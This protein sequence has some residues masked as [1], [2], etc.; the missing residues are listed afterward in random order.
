MLPKS[1]EM[2]GGSMKRLLVVGMV[3]SVIY[4]TVGYAQAEDLAKQLAELKAQTTALQKQLKT[5]H[6][7]LK[8]IRNSK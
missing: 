5:L 4:S 7:I 3:F 6:N 8:A 1:E 2:M